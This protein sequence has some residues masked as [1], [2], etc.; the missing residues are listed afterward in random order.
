MGGPKETG[1]F[2]RLFMVPGMA[3]C[4]G[5]PGANAFGQGA[6]GPNPADPASDILSALDYWVD[7]RVAPE[8]IIATKYVNDDRNQ[9][10]AFQRPLCPFPKIAKYRAHGGGS[11][12]DASSFECSHDGGDGDHD[13]DRDHHRDERADNR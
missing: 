12:T 5:G 11:T 13:G 9:G 8:K 3:H 10:V 4:G 2:Y 6:N 1:E 7:R